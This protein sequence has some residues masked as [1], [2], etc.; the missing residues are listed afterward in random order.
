MSDK[1]TIFGWTKKNSFW[2]NIMLTKISNVFV[3]FTETFFF[4]QHFTIKLLETLNTLLGSCRFQPT[5]FFF[6]GG[7]GRGLGWTDI[8][9]KI[10]KS[11]HL[12]KHL[13]LDWTET[14]V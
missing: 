9:D 8:F 13:V 7:G 12:S 4:F 5:C 10:M 6:G 11:P 3:G 2:A 1:V 14:K